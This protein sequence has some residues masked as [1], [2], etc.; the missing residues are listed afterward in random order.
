LAEDIDANDLALRH[1]DPE[2]RFEL[3]RFEHQHEAEIACGLLHAN[4]IPCELSSELLPGLPGEIILWTRTKDADLAWA[5]LADAER[6][7]SRG[8]TDQ[9]GWK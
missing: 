1:V 6:E 8:K 7:S 4:G 5:L 9:S 2:E 3:D